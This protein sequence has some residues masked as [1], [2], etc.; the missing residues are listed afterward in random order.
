MTSSEA[1][2]ATILPS[3]PG[4]DAFLAVDKRP[5]IAVHGPGGLLG[6]LREEFGEGLALVH[7][8]DKETSGV[9]LLARGPDALRAAH[10]AW[11]TQVEK[12]YVAV[13]RGV[14]EPSE[15]RVDA[16]LL[17][18]RTSRP[19][20]LKRAVKA[21]YGPS[22]AGHLL[23]GRRVLAIQPL[24]PP[25][26]TAVHPAGRPAATRYRVLENRGATAL[27]ELVPE[28]GRMHQ[29]RI[30]LLHLGTPLLG[31]SAY[32]AEHKPGDP[33]ARLHAARLVWTDPPG[34]PPGTVW[35]WEA[36]RPAPAVP[37]P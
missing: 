31:D 10:A 19:D 7:R 9:L 5:G 22:R 21:A 15:G 20:L 37:G 13:T 3:P 35:I 1:R 33:P 16:P 27:V 28:T 4:A 12:T 36:P 6:A 23:S 11:P 17:E 29:L 34:M 2:T 14:P 18:H 25:G 26:R 24:P 32:D 30:H 8:L